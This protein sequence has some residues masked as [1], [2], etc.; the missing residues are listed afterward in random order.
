[1]NASSDDGGFDP[2]FQEGEVDLEFDPMV[3]NDDDDDDTYWLSEQ[4]DAETRIRTTGTPK[5]D[6]W[7]N[8]PNDELK[9]MD[10]TIDRAREQ[11]FN[12][13]KTEIIDILQK[14]WGDETAPSFEKLAEKTFG[15]NSGLFLLLKVELDLSYPTYCRFMATFYAACQRKMPVSQMLKDK[16]LD[17]TG[18]VSFVEYSKILRRIES[19][20][21]NEDTGTLGE[22]LWMKLEDTYNKQVK[23]IFLQHRGHSQLCLSLDDDKQKY[24]YSKNANTFGLLRTRH[25]QKNRFGVN[26]HT[27]ATAATCIVV[28]VMYQRQLESLV[29]IYERMLRFMFGDRTGYGPLNLQGITLN[30]DRGYWTAMLLFSMLLQWGADVV[31]T[32]ARCYWFPFVYSKMKDGN[33]TEGDKHNRTKVTTK[34]FRD[35]LF[36]IIKLPGNRVLRAIAFRSGTGNVS[37]AMSTI[38]HYN[39]FDFNTAFPK[40]SK[41]AFLNERQESN[42]TRNRRP[43]RLVCGSNEAAALSVIMADSPVLPV[44]TVQ[45]DACWFQCRKFGLTSSTTY[46][47][48]QELSRDIR[49]NHPLRDE[50]ETLLCAIGREE[51]LLLEEEEEEPST[52]DNSNRTTTTPPVAPDDDNAAATAAAASDD[53]SSLACYLITNI[54]KQDIRDD[55]LQDLENKTITEETIRDIVGR[56]KHGKQAAAITTLRKNLKGWAERPSNLHRQYHWYSVAQLKHRIK[57]IDARLKPVGNKEAV[58]QALVDCEIKQTERNEAIA[59]G[60]VS[61]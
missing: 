57:E 19:I 16:R 24:N 11:V 9:D 28:C 56:H 3:G 20:G 50:I 34:G 21:G 4:Q 38:H 45:G 40:D 8:V 55:F 46:K 22:S 39:R 26:L 53:S 52:G 6:E 23:D 44:T 54:H 27:A 47:A 48:V 12:Q 33:T 29:Q 35:T 15:Q 49:S 17:K 60:E 7:E 42:E 14:G 41:W 31:G 32:V 2:F 30:T 61:G 36:K 59:N 43:F 51:W 25:I 13:A 18:F 58:L 37:L 5:A 1:M 10:V